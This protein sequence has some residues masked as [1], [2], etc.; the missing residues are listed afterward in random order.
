MNLEDVD[1]FLVSPRST[2][3][4]RLDDVDFGTPEFAA[5]PGCAH[6]RYCCSRKYLKFWAFGSHHRGSVG[7][8]RRG[9]ARGRVVRTILQLF[10]WGIFLW[11]VYIS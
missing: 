11:G 3:D 6:C 10:L 1:R 4:L 2:V 9:T 8:P 5:R 7:H